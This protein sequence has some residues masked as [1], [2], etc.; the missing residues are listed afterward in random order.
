MPVRSRRFGIFAAGAALALS[1]CAAVDQKVRGA[2]PAIDQS[3]GVVS[4]ADPRAAEAGAEMLR[5]GGSATD[6]A[7][8]TM[9]ALGVVEP[10]S[11]GIGGGGFL[12][13]ARPGG[14]VE[15]FD[16]RETAPSAAGPDWFMADGR[17][18][19]YAEAVPGGKGVGV[20]GNLRLAAM[21]HARSGHLPWRVLF[22]PAIRLA[23]DGFVITPRLNASLAL[24][25]GPAAF[26]ADGRALFFGK[27]GAPLPS[28]TRVR[29][30]A[31]AR[32]LDRI[33]RRG[34]D[35]FYRGDHA[36]RIVG[37]V[38]ASSRTPAPMSTADI[39]TYA[40]VPRPPV[41]GTYRAWRI[42]GMG[43]PSAGTIIVIQVLGQLERFDMGALGKTSPVAWHLIAEAERLAYADRDRYVADPGF[44][45]V[46]VAGL[47]DRD[48]I[49]RRSAL[50]SAGSAMKAVSAGAPA[51][52]VADYRPAAPAPE[53]GT[54]HFAAVDRWGEAASYTSTIESGFGSGIVVDGYYLNNELTDFSFAGEVGGLTVAN[55][56]EPGK[57]PRSS[58][59]PVVA[60]DPEGRLALAAGAA[61]GATIP[62]QVIRL[63]IGKIDWGLS[64][65]EAISLGVVMPAGEG[66][67]VEA[68]SPLEQMVPALSAL[69]HASVKAVPM[70]L[71]ANAIERTAADWRGA[72]DPRSE[73]AA[74]T[75]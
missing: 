74:V 46:P 37:A 48:Y 22:A 30:P 11:S 47:I 27:D 24:F 25:R 26:D 34:P 32:L 20:P 8:A 29:N 73:G 72:A 53:H 14:A 66:I 62:A 71:K 49:A 7:I 64:A 19:T 40:A 3:A 36:A 15:T 21:G 59:S 65:R 10:Q 58:M 2:A 9:L 44:V 31:F 54:S 5:K 39:G 4:A 51:G 42:C 6:A 50:I 18:L 28:G 52:I 38:R 57:R 68:G 67:T 43:P 69:G 33:A 13:L 12:V 55:R 16:G 61:G 56:V 35:A 75:P 41:C 17:R 63:L 45:S 60:Y 70:R 23:R 1:G